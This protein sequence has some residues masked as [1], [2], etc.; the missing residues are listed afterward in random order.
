LCPRWCS[1]SKK[2]FAQEAKDAGEYVE[3]FFVPHLYNPDLL[4]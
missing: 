4:I 3:M 2:R 1:T